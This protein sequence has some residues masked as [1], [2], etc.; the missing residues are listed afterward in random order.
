MWCHKSV[1]SA[2]VS[3]DTILLSE[4]YTTFRNL[5]AQ[6]HIVSSDTILLSEMYIQNGLSEYVSLNKTY[7]I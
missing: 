7:K 3:S 1:C 4:I 5:S 2:S 6:L